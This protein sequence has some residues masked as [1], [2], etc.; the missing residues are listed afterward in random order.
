[1]GK[2]AIREKVI[3]KI[4]AIENRPYLEALYNFI[5]ASE[6]PSSYRLSKEEKDAIKSS[7]VQIKRGNSFSQK[8]VEKNLKKWLREK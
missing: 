2:L 7:R 6:P 3:K 4:E 1:M 8:Q 5:E